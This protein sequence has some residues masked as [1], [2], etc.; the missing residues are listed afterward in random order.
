MDLLNLS[1][2][3]YQLEESL[4]EHKNASADVL[5]LQNGLSHLI[6]AA[7]T[8]KISSPI[9]YVDIPGAYFFTEGNLGGLFKLENAYAE[10]KF[11]LT[12]EDPELL[13]MVQAIKD[14]SDS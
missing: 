3:A 4:I 7:K 13:A 11:A 9:D 12:D 2:L 10:F 14:E 8:G 1:K 5:L 6:E